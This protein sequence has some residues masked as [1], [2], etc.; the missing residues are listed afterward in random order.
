MTELVL[1][2]SGISDIRSHG[3]DKARRL[4]DDSKASRFAVDGFAHRY[5]LGVR[6]I[7]GTS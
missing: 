2:V 7:P 5:G 1:G 3:D 4:P 6:L